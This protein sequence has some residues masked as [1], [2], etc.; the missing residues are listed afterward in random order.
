MSDK[1]TYYAAKATNSSRTV[2]T[3]QHQ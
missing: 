2:I 1:D 3:R